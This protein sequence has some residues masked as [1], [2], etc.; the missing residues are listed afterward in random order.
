MAPIH[1]R[2]PA[3]LRLEDE[4]AWLASTNKNVP[5][6]LALLQ[7]YPDEELEAYAVSK[8]VNAPTIDDPGCVLPWG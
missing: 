1:N 6:L 7:P 5:D 3:I 8:A 2:M 4:A